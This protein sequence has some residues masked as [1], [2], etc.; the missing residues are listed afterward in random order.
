M[1]NTVSIS[2]ASTFHWF[3]SCVIL[4]TAD[5]AFS[6]VTSAKFKKSSVVSSSSSPVYP[7]LVLISPIAD[8]VSSKEPVM[9]EEYALIILSVKLFKASPVAP[10]ASTIVLSASEKASVNSYTASAISLIA[11]VIPAAANALAIPS[12]AA[13][14]F[15]PVSPIFS[16]ASSSS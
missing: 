12:I 9:L 11:F 8:A 6:P 14:P 1:D 3:I 15:S 5:A 4:A 2:L 13:I 10:V 16:P 7:S